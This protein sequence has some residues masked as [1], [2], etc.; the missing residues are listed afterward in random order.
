[1]ICGVIG[2][3]EFTNDFQLTAQNHIDQSTP[4]VVRI[5]ELLCL[6]ASVGLQIVHA[7]LI[8]VETP[9]LRTTFL[10]SEIML[11]VACTAF[12]IRYNSAILFGLGFCEDGDETG[13]CTN[14][15]WTGTVGVIFLW[16]LISPFYYFTV[17]PIRDAAADD[18][19]NE[20]Q[21]LKHGNGERNV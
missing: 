17:N 10:V 4:H 19:N 3:P 7:K 16:V 9:G 8:L 14:E 18:V 1:M 6:A 2:F 12:A 15:N 21:Q 13:L 11:M 5:I 20:K